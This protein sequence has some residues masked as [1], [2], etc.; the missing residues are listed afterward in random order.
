MSYHDPRP[1][2]TSTSLGSIQETRASKRAPGPD[3]RRL[4]RIRDENDADSRREFVEIYGPP[5]LAFLKHKQIGA[6]QVEQLVDYMFEIIY[7]RLLDFRSP[8][9]HARDWTRNLWRFLWMDVQDQWVREAG[10][11][12]VA[13][14]TPEEFA[15]SLSDFMDRRDAATAFENT[16]LRLERERPATAARDTRIF[17]AWRDRVL[18]AEIARREKLNESQVV[19]VILRVKRIFTE[20]VNRL[21]GDSS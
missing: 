21:T 12:V 10:Y 9:Y 2:R 11:E 1:D 14:I 8:Q 15:K 4:Y 16:C 13:S 17:L 19:L 5:T 18:P 20:E 6:G 7:E 3:T